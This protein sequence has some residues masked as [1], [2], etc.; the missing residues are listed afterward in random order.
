MHQKYP[1]RIVKAKWSGNFGGKYSITLKVIGNDDIGIVTNIT[2]VISKEKNLSLRSIS[3]DSI[4]GLFQGHL[5][6]YVENLNSLNT[7]IKKIQSVKG[8]KF[9]ERMS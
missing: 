9:V 4:D 8:V 1:Y 3:I 5:S 7:L 2:S 6:V